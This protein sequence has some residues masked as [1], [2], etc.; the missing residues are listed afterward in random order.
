LP[1][2]WIPRFATPYVEE[3][4]TGVPVPTTLLPDYSRSDQ[5]L[6]KY[7]Q[8][9]QRFPAYGK[10]ELM[11]PE[12]S[13]R[14]PRTSAYPIKKESQ[15]PKPKVDILTGDYYCPE[16]S[17]KSQGIP[18]KGMTVAFDGWP[19]S[20]RGPMKPGTNSWVPDKSGPSTSIRASYPGSH[21]PVYPLGLLY[22]MA[23]PLVD[24]A[25]L[26]LIAPAMKPLSYK[27]YK[28]GADPDAHTKSFE[29]ILWINVETNELV[30]MILL[31]T[32]LTD[33][34]QKWAD[35]YLDMHPN[36]TWE[37]FKVAFKKCYWEQQIDEQ[38]YAALKTLKKGDNERVEDY[39]E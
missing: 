15:M 32:T 21:R 8:A 5:K 23:P 30:V 24:Q 7:N 14:D 1:K 9:E 13:R 12:L 34:V 2:E 36:C 18:K 37:Q 10:T 31:C 6:P 38:V 17:K 3:P 19:F 4:V 11:M 26:P 29:K 20:N 22:P 39:Y 27:M 33:K 25:V 35:D 28:E 16:Q